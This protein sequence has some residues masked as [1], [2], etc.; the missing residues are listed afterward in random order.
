[1]SE[2]TIESVGALE[3]APL[4]S[5]EKALTADE[6]ADL[7]RSQPAGL[8]AVGLTVRQ[9]NTGRFMDAHEIATST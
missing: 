2:K 3:S 5:G 8:A 1:M 6:L 4:I 7:G 9:R